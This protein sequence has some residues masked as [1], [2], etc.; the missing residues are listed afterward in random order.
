MRAPARRLLPICRGSYRPAIL[1][2]IENAGL[3][4]KAIGS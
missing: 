4:S 2:Q 1:I 3:P